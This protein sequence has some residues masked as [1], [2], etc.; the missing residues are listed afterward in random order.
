MRRIDYV[1]R[2]MV[3]GIDGS[4]R[5]R[6]AWRMGVATFAYTYRYPLPYDDGRIVRIGFWYALRAGWQNFVGSLWPRS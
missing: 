2:G 4:G 5:L 3:S 6:R 1:M